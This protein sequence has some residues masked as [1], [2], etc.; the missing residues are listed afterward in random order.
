MTMIKGGVGGKGNHASNHAG[1]LLRTDDNDRVEFLEHDESAVS[2]EA[3]L[4]EMVAISRHLCGSD[5]GF[6]HANINPHPGDRELTNDEWIKAADIL[7]KHLEFEGQ[8]RV[9]VLHEKNDRTHIHIVWQRTDTETG[10]LRDYKHNYRKHENAAREIE[11]ELDLTLYIHPQEKLRDAPNYG[12]KETQQA[13]RTGQSVQERKA[14]I[15][16]L[17]HQSEDNK[18]FVA[19]L[20]K[21]GWDLAQGDKAKGAFMIVDPAGE[22]FPLFRQITDKKLRAAEFRKFMEPMQPGHFKR[23][24]QIKADMVAEKSVPILPED[25]R[26]AIEAEY[27]KKSEEMSARHQKEIK[28]LQERYQSKNNDIGFEML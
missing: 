17:Y 22:A 21:H 7:E 19:A 8:K 3:E 14:L 24:S 4:K 12:H 6:Y 15:T 26:A 16:D 11:K 20:R 10:K 2:L 23:V 13:E 5:L 25:P 1:H 28:D 27:D 9:I 18:A